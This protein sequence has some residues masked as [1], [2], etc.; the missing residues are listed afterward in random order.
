MA[1]AVA[2]FAPSWAGDAIAGA[3]DISSAP[4]SEV[5]DQDRSWCTSKRLPVA[6]GMPTAT[7]LGSLFLRSGEGG[8]EEGSLPER[9]WRQS[10]WMRFGRSSPARIHASTPWPHGVRPPPCAATSSPP[11]PPVSPHAAS[12]SRLELPWLLGFDPEG[13]G[14]KDWMSL[15]GMG[16]GRK[17]L[18]LFS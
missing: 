17:P 1:D 11:A 4:R 9:N 10:C 14:H 15:C 12:S 8:R 5:N 6:A 3:G 7:D 13:G 2:F 16:W 18:R